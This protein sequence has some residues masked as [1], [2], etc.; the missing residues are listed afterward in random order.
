[1]PSALAAR[2]RRQRSAREIRTWLRRSCHSQMLF[3]RLSSILVIAGWPAVNRQAMARRQAC[4]APIA[5]ALA[6]AAAAS[7]AG[8]SSGCVVD[9]GA[10]TGTGYYLAAVLARLPG[11]A[12]VA[13]DLSKRAIRVAARAHRRIGRVGCDA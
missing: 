6:D 5:A 13:L 1:M 10:G 2:A 7:V 8:R 12:G 4:F 11:H 3:C 9:V